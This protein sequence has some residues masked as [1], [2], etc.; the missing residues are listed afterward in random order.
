MGGVI[1]LLVMF[2]MFNSEARASTTFTS[3]ST[4]TVH[5]EDCEYT[6]TISFTCA[7]YAGVPIP[8][9]VDSY[10]S[11]D[12]SCTTTL[13]ED[14]IANAIS[15][16][17]AKD[18][19]WHDIDCSSGYPPCS[20]QYRGVY[21]QTEALCFKKYNYGAGIMLYACYDEGYCFTDWE[22]CFDGT[23]IISSEVGYYEDSGWSCDATVPGPPS[24]GSFS[25]CFKVVTN[26][27]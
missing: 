20:G 13:S 26:C 27:D 4:V 21:T 12:P 19:S 15:N 7:P 11:S 9:M 1:L 22:Y 24:S 18:P 23:D 10:Y 14:E 6:V 16:E 2:V 8:Y 25:T 17:I 3:S 5:L